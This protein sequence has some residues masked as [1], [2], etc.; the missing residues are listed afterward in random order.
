MMGT[1]SLPSTNT[2]TKNL[3][4]S[5]RWVLVVGTGLRDTLPYPE[6]LAARAVGRQLAISGCGLITGGWDGVDYL[7]VDSFIEQLHKQ[8]LD[9][10]DYV[11]QVIPEHWEPKHQQGHILR[12]PPGGREW[13]EPQ[14]F[15]EVIILVGGKG[16]T[17][18]A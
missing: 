1:F 8:G 4:F 11:I 9:P 13:L 7:V 2:N 18:R 5:R 6:Q 14:K 17:Y 15:A 3:P 12:T 10:T 16:G